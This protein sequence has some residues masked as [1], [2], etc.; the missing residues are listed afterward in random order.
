[1]SRTA[2]TTAL[3]A[4]VAGILHAA[5]AG[6][7]PVPSSP[8]A[9]PANVGELEEVAVTGSRISSLASYEQ[10]TPVTVVG[11]EILERENHT[12]LI[13]V[14]Q[15]VPAVGASSNPN[16][17]NGSQSVSAGTAGLS[18]VNLRNLGSNRTLVLFDGMRVVPSTQGGGVDLNLLP[19]SLVQRI[20]VVTGGAS[21]AWGSDAV[22]G[23]VN[24][25]LNKRFDGVQAHV[26]GATN[27]GRT[28]ET[29][30]GELSYGTP[31]F[32]GRGHVIV[33]GAYMNSPDVVNPQ[34]TSWYRSQNL[35]NNPA[36]TATN[37]QPRLIHAENVG[38]SSATQGG[39]ITGGPLRGIQFVGPK[40]TPAPFN[41]GNVSGTLSNGGTF[42]NPVNSGQA[43]N[44]AIPIRTTTFLGYFSYDLTDTT[45]MSVELNYGDSDT[46]NGSASYTRQGNLTIQRD[47]PFLDEGIRQRMF[48]LNITSFPLGTTNVN[49]L[50]N[51]GSATYTEASGLGNLF[52]EVDRKLFRQVLSLDGRLGA[53]R[54][55]AFG[56]H[57]RV[58]RHT[59]MVVDPVVANYNR[60]VDA[61]RVTAQNVGSSGLPIG[62]I[63]CRSTLL[64]P[65]NGCV[66]LNVLG[67]GVASPEAIAYVNN[68]PAA[69]DL[70]LTQW[71]AG[72]SFEGEPFSTWAGPVATALGAEYRK[73]TAKQTA[74]ALSYQRAYA[75][76]NFQYFDAK[77]SVYEGFAELNVPLLK[78]SVVQSLDA[79][80]AARL[81][82]YSSSGK[83]TTWK[84]GLT[85]QLHEMVRIRGTASS[86]IRAPSLSDLYNPGSTSI[87]VVTDPFR[88]GN[89]TTNIFALNSG[90]P[91]LDPEKARTY[92]A[93]VVLTPL[94][95]LSASVDW[96]SIDISGAI[97]S[98][99]FPYTLAQCY[100]GNQIFCPLIQRNEQGV[101]TVIATS[102]VNAASYRTSGIDFQADYK[103]AAF[104]G[105][106]AMSVIGNYAKELVIDS[107]GVVVQQAGS[108]NRAPPN[109]GTSGAPKLR[110]NLTAT[111]SRD[112]WTV[113]AQLR[114][115]GEA[116]LNNAW[117][118]KDVDD[119]SV[120]AVAFLDLRASLYL[121][122]DRQYQAYL[123]V[124]NVLSRDPPITPHGPQA[125]ITY[126]YV[127]TRTDIYDA[128]GRSFRMGFRAK[129]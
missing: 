33:S 37:D 54:W 109:E 46:T 10:P 94:P 29:A 104:G 123:A 20:D 55:S 125:G 100:A 103:L 70:L 18:L 68:G 90:N 34:Q 124:D 45:K 17:S 81:T 22:A 69:S 24:V 30:K 32:D 116:K 19:S 80:G 65:R 13:S 60:A 107:L 53:W 51:D 78:D 112:A 40:G 8:P 96:Y 50:P 115:F 16:T 56:Q 118:P 117:G 76:G 83:V 77:D 99:S 66:P 89:P 3:A 52:N 35:V 129:F 95:G 57:S 127:P 2:V 44:I 82:R 102:P 114:G 64:D 5:A 31:L 92:T 6:A 87:Q 62:S 110:G 85:S 1:M 21:A 26:E 98:P 74:D 48:D 59:H 75:A 97:V 7:Q 39:L 120:P 108:L 38:L 36:Y 42:E 67:V 128:L 113:A 101:I 73:D 11:M 9:K 41:F 47:N 23:V 15:K 122:E 49:S 61:V 58:D 86:D 28:R 12:D 93:G 27:E 63:A 106:L 126:F 79:N 111:Y 43:N 119:N 91:N 88:P 72:F 105:Q 14:M 25:I 121:G 4:L 71:T 84:L